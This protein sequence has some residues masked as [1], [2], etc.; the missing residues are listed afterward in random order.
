[1]Q[2]DQRLP[3]G[4]K[5][6]TNSYSIRIRPIQHDLPKSLDTRLDIS[7]TL[8]TRAA[9]DL[10]YAMTASVLNISAYDTEFMT[11]QRVG[12]TQILRLAVDTRMI[13]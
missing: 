13:F 4:R 11:L 6:T 7:D 5:A 2:I 9:R 10:H 3:S 1:M 12:F 8:S